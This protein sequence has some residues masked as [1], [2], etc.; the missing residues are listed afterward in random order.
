MSKFNI[1]IVSWQ[2]SHAFIELG[3]PRKAFCPHPSVLRSPLGSAA[4]SGRMPPA[5]RS[6]AA[7]TRAPALDSRALGYHLFSLEKDSQPYSELV[8][9]EFKG[10]RKGTAQIGRGNAKTIHQSEG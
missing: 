5:G 7:D 10:R 2:R 3:V 9:H 6:C 1:A 8:I 4:F